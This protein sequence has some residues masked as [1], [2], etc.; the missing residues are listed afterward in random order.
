MK[1]RSV[2]GLRGIAAFNVAVSHFVA[3]FLPSM[4]HK[5]YP[6]TFGKN[7]HPSGLFDV[8]TSPM[9]SIFYNGHF[10]VLIFF[11]LSGYVLTM[12]YYNQDESSGVLSKRLWGRYLRLNIPICFAISISYVVYVSGLYLNVHAADMS[13]ST[14]W[15]KNFFPSGI[16][17]SDAV[18]ESVFQSII[19]GNSALIPPLW[20]LKIEFIGSLYVLLFYISKPKRYTF[21]S[22]L[23]VLLLIY[24]IHRQD[25]IYFYAIFLGSFLNELKKSSRLKAVFFFIGFYFGGFQFEN[26]IYNFLPRVMVGDLEVWDKKTFY[27]LIGAC[28]ITASVVQGFG[29]KILQWRITQFFGGISFSLYL[30]HFVILC[31]LSS[32]VYVSLSMGKASLLVNF[33]CYVLVC[34]LVSFIFEKYIDKPSISIAH[35]FSKKIF[36]KKV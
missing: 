26:S 32:Y 9:V 28:F 10:A 6:S 3:A 1:N 31:S 17:L 11:V 25:S 4:L 35:K 16:S 23:M 24:V 8:L 30:L 21:L 19:F 5:N 12:P 27:N 36:S 34:V 15:L 29:E 33:A 2:D 22:A 20:T 7:Q 18:K 14:E 13:G